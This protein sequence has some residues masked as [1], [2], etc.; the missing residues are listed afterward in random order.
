MAKEA[1]ES[2]TKGTSVFEKVSDIL[3][4]HKRSWIPAGGWVLFGGFFVNCVI[5]PFASFEEIEW[6]WLSSAFGLMLVISGGRDWLLD[7]QS[8]TSYKEVEV[9]G[10]ISRVATVGKRYWISAIGWCL[11]FGLLVDLVISPFAK[12][13]IVS[14]W[15]LVGTFAGMMGISWGRDIALKSNAEKAEAEAARK[16]VEGP[17]GADIQK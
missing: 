3:I 5:F 8:P 15:Y 13:N 4:R 12:V 11:V 17:T 7:K 9:D 10:K 1:K 6:E 16:A 14:F 2:K